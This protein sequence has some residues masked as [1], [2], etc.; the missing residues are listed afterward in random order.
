APRLKRPHAPRPAV[1]KPRRGRR[2]LCGRGAR[3]ATPTPAA[4][5]RGAGG[6]GRS[7]PP[8]PKRGSRRTGWLLMRRDCGRCPRGGRAVEGRA[9][10]LAHPAPAAAARWRARSEGE[11]GGGGGPGCVSR[12]GPETAVSSTASITAETRSR[13]TRRMRAKYRR[14]SC[15]VR[16]PY[17]EGAW[18][19][20]PTHGRSDGEPAS[21]P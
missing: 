17:T 6:P 9:P 12:S 11:E 19:T 8:P 16:S 2:H 1:G 13:E 14:F 18:V 15:T 21:S 5:R 10:P 3:P 7:S 4:R 20:Y